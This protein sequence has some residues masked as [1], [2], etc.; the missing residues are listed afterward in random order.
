MSM[1][2]V[3]VDLS[4][5]RHS[6]LGFPVP[7]ESESGLVPNCLPEGQLGS[8]KEAHSHLRFIRRGK[9]AGNRVTEPGGYELITDF[10]RSGRDLRALSARDGPDFVVE[11]T[12]GSYKAR[13]LV[14]A[15]GAI[16]ARTARAER[17]P[18][19][20]VCS[21]SMSRATATPRHC[22]QAMCSSLGADSLDA[23]LRKSCMLLGGKYCWPAVELPGAPEEL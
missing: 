23:K 2:V 11:T 5:P 3:A 21:R 1:R 9:A 6:L 4:K 19:L 22:L 10:C 17:V 14:L 18:C 7:E 13:S 16:N 12:S 8:R 20:L 15:T